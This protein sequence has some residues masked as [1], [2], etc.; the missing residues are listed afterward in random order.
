MGSARGVSSGVRSAAA[1]PTYFFSVSLGVNG[2]RPAPD[3]ARR[4]SGRAIKASQVGRRCAKSL[5]VV[6]ALACRAAGHAA[7]QAS[8]VTAARQVARRHS[9]A[10]VTTLAIDAPP[11]AAE[12]TAANICTVGIV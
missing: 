12:K 3:A 9:R 1:H 2:S 6:L 4:T 8:S 10:N 7:A 11:S 5:S